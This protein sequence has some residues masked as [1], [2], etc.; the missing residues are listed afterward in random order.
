MT[1]LADT[2]EIDCPPPA[3][4]A[5]LRPLCGAVE[6]A[7]AATFAVPVKQLRRRSRGAASVAFARQSA[8][9][10]AHVALR[11]TYAEIG[12]G[13]GRDRTT[14]AYACRLI[15]ERRDDPVIDG[16]LEALEEVC[17]SLLRRHA[18]DGN[19]SS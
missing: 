11:L 16:L 10:L 3:T 12:E 4:P 1:R 6:A 13:F 5:S 18:R 8:M 15:E 17:Q 2:R 14:A 7:V 19:V 9:Y